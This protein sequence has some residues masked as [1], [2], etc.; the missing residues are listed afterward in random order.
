M[1]IL[2]R[3][4]NFLSKIEGWLIVLMLWLMVLLTFIQVG[5]RSLYTYG[6]FQWANALL[7]SIDWS[8]PF[9]S[10]LVLWLTFLGASL[11]TKEGKHINIDLF[12]SLLPERWLP[13][14]EVLLALVCVF[15]SAIMVK[16][17]IDHIRM[18]M[19]FG[20]AAFFDLPAWSGQI[21]LPAGFALLFFHFLIKA[22]HEGVRLARG[23]P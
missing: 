23:I 18:E 2:K 22:L 1:N 12:S 21:I 11:L 20:G 6:H 10:L 9:V 19:V 13:M 16:V 7:G 14:R 5:L 4:D 15:I 17:S 8:G 3:I